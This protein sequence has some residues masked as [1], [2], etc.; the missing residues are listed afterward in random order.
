MKLAAPWN[1]WLAEPLGR[2]HLVHP[3]ADD[4]TLVES[5]ALYTASGLNRGDA[6]VLVLTADRAAA[7]RARMQEDGFDVSDLEQ[8]R[9]LRIRDAEATLGTFLVDGQ[10]EA[11]VASQAGLGSRNGRLRVYGEMVDLLNRRGATDTAL[12]LEG[13]WNEAVSVHAFPL[14]CAYHVAPGETLSPPLLEAHTHVVPS[15]ACA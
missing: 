11:E 14:L 8:W 1:D 4:R 6:V 15:H 10:P 5:L 9:Q 12:A 13:L 2:D 3:Y 7:L